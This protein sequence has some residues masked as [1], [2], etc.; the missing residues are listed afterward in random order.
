MSMDIIH[1]LDD[2]KVFAP[3]FRDPET[4]KSWRAYLAACSRFP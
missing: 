1:A 2:Q 3:S 4:W